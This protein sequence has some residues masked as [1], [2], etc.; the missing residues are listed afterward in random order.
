MKTEVEVNMLEL[1]T[2]SLIVCQENLLTDKMQVNIQ[3]LLYPLKAAILTC[4]SLLNLAL[5][6]KCS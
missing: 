6:V 1:P 3:I 2:I 5:E 4:D